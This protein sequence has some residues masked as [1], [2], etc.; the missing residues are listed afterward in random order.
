MRKFLFS[1]PTELHKNIQKLAVTNDTT[2]TD[3]INASL[4]LLVSDEIPEEYRENVISWANAQTCLKRR[5]RV[6]N[7]HKTRLR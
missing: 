4:E 6:R 2:I 7:F 5:R 3:V 1:I